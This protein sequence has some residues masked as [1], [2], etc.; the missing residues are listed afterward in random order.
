[1]KSVCSKTLSQTVYK[2]HA[3]LQRRMELVSAAYQV[4]IKKLT[5]AAQGAFILEHNTVI[6]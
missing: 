5:W 3:S 6:H 2:A 1:M 4:I